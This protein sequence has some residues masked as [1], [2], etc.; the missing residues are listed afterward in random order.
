[1][2][3]QIINVG[4]SAN[5][6]TGDTLRVSQ[7]K[8]NSNFDELYA[9]SGGGSVGTLQQVTDNGATTDVGLTALDAGIYSLSPTPTT[10]KRLIGMQNNTN[11]NS[12]ALYTRNTGDFISELHAGVLTANREHKLPDG[13]GTFMLK[14]NNL[15][16]VTNTATARTNL[17]VAKKTRIFLT[18]DIPNTT[19]ADI[20]VT[21]FTFTLPASG[22]CDFRVCLPFTSGA[23]GTG[24]NIG[25]KIVT[26]VGANGNVLGNVFAKTRLST[27]TTS[28][29]INVVDQGANATV[30]YSAL[31]GVSTTGL[32]NVS[33]VNCDLTNLSTNTSVTVQIV[34]ASETAG[35]SVDIK[36]GASM[37]I[38]I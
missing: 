17:E 15:S 2:A 34:F 9:G 8:A 10:D 27:T 3:Q 7:Q 31:S 4:T 29:I 19:V 33:E 30:S 37:V 23:T 5:D 28:P 6:G 20:D 38:D 35:V 14:E 11:A 16:D 12:G 1:M 32:T 25:V 22:K 13:D 26:G 24:I 21:G 36:R 18:S